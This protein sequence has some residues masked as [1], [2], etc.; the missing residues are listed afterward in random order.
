M[1]VEMNDDNRFDFAHSNSALKDDVFET[2]PIGFF[3]D[4][5]IRFIHNK[6]AVGAMVTITFIV[7]MSFIGP[8]MN[9][10]SFKE[11][12]IKNCYVPA[13]IPILENFGIADGSMIRRVRETSI[14]TKYKNSLISIEK[15][16]ILRNINMADIKFNVYKKLGI[17][18]KYYWFGTDSLGRD[19]WTRL[20]RG[21][22]ISLLIAVIAMS[23][24]IF[25]GVIYGAV[26][27]Y[28]GGAI[29]LLMQ[30]IV[31]IIAGIPF[32]VVIIL[33]ILYFGAGIKAIALALCLQG[34]IGMSRM[35]RAQF[36]RY[37][38]MEYV[39]ASR[40]LGANDITLIFR[41]I[42]PNAIGIL[43][44]MA[45]LSIPYAIFSEAFLAFLGLGI[46]A[47]EPSI[48]VLLSEGQ[49]SLIDYPYLTF[50]PGV[51][52]SILMVSFNLLGNGLRDAF[53]PTLRGQ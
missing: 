4:A 29:D 40:T 8:L 25:I 24:N 41:H 42:L 11:Q 19:Q 18:D 37:K 26:S 5:M 7:L 1:S 12:N 3:K 32:M 22:R 17:E 44:T 43:I 33:F 46:Q 36:Y 34:W 15:R 38:G 21:V 45:A 16:Y 23:I 31:E 14:E 52:I 20:W 30:R 10:Y 35:I 50:F 27:G 53:D 49:R 2:E 48:G 47:P 51:L 13:R 39:L 6:V 9:E 28:Y